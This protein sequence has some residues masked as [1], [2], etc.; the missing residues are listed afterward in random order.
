M[1]QLRIAIY[2]AFCCIAA[3]ITSC[4]D[5]VEPDYNCPELA[6][7]NAELDPHEVIPHTWQL[8]ICSSPD[9]SFLAYHS[10]YGR[11]TVARVLNMQ[12]GGEYEFPDLKDR[13]LPSFRLAD[14]KVIDWCPYDKNRV[15]LYCTV[16]TENPITHKKRIGAA[17]FIYAL[18]GSELQRLPFS[19]CDSIY[20]NIW[21]ASKWLPRSRPGNDV[22]QIFAETKDGVGASKC[23]LY[24]YYHWQSNTFTEYPLPGN[25]DAGTVDISQKEKYT[26]SMSNNPNNNSQKDMSYFINGKRVYLEGCSQLLFM[27]NICVFSPDETRLALLVSA[28][29]SGN[30]IRSDRRGGSYE[31]WVYRI[32]D[33]LVSDASHPTRRERQINLLR[34]FC[35]FPLPAMDYLTNT[36]FVVSLFKDPQSSYLY[37]ISTE[38]KMLRQLTTKP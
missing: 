31:I 1:N 38:G 9:G 24:G 29:E 20:N 18:D 12:T 4:S 13:L 34:N 11:P 3:F 2:F 26:L 10:E 19:D 14:T 17:L 5:T 33:L 37:E 30:Y 6:W 22:F 36:S 35:A 23:L 32:K 15:L 28:N 7:A 25:T 8:N 27:P 16:G 21:V